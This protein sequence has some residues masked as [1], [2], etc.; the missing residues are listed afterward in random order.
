MIVLN[1]II[2]TRLYFIV[3]VPT[4]YCLS[5]KIIIIHISPKVI[6]NILDINNKYDCNLVG[7][8]RAKYGIFLTWKGILTVLNPNGPVKKNRL[9]KNIGYVCDL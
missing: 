3:S 4:F 5:I 1:G 8:Q 9:R 6:N 7:L 2:I